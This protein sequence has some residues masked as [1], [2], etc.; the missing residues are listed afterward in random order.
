[1]F[2]LFKIGFLTV[3]FTDMLDIIIVSFIIYELYKLLK[4][5][6]ASQIFIGLMIILVL[7]FISQAANF[8]DIK[9]AVK[10]SNRYLGNRIPYSFPAGNTKTPC[11]C[12]K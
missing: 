12:C 4:G 5:T 11:V 1:M 2:D 6:I 9:L 3:T 8:K 10:I 7:S